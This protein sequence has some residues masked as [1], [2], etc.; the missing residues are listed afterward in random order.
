MQ[1]RDDTEPSRRRLLDTSGAECKM[2]P[3]ARGLLDYFPDALAEV[4]K[5]SYLGNLKHNPGEEMHHARGRAW[6]TR[7]HRAASGRA[8]RL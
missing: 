3:M 7:M 8:R 1:Y 5:L 4:A 2:F 6:I